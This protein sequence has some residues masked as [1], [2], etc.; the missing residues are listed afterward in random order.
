MMCS[1]HF[2]AM[3]EPFS[4][5]DLVV[6]RQVMNTIINLANAADMN[7]V[8]VVTHDVTAA[9][10]VSDHI[11][12]MGRDHNADGSSIPGARIVEEYDLIERDLCWHPEVDK[13][14]RFTDTVREI[15]ERFKT[16][17]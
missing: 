7:T 9:V 14:P 12:M 16:L 1:E 6:Q 17:N 11:W 13:Q 15:K 2:L 10:S 3:D 4:G 5:L 8:I